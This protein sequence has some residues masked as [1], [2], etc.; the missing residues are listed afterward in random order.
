MKILFVSS[1]VYPLVKTGGLA[2]VAGAL[3]VALSTTCDVK[4]MLPAYEGML[5]MFEQVTNGPILGNPFGFG[6][7]CLRF[8]RLEGLEV[9]FWLVDCPN[10]FHRQG[11]PYLNDDGHDHADNHRRFA[12]LSWA[13]AVVTQYGQLMNWRPD[14]VHAHDWQTGLL[15][16]YLKAWAQRHP[17]LVYTIHN[18]QFTGAYTHEQYI[19]TGLPEHLYNVAGLEY[20]GRYSMLKAGIQYSDAVTTVSPTY[21]KE[22]Q[23]PAFGCGLDALMRDQRHKLSGI[24]NGVDYEVWNPA[25]DEMIDFHYS[26]RDMSG[27]ALNKH[28][29]QKKLGLLEDG[30]RPMFGLIS[31]LSEQKGL[32]L[33]LQVMPEFLEQGV[34]FVLLGSGEKNLESSFRALSGR[35]PEQVAVNFGYNEPLAH[36]IQAASDFLLVPSRFEPCG[37]TQLYALKYGTLPIVRRTGGLA[38]SVWEDIPGRPQTGFTLNEASTRDLW[39]A[40]TRALV[41]YENERLLRQ[42]REQAM[43]QDFSWESAA[44]Q[45]LSLYKRLVT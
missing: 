45:Y 4:V 17:P 23:T 10:L 35:F 37:L 3:P 31:R 12:A 26:T 40:M 19:E 25:T 9:D 21:A 7:L 5:G 33:V 22:I 27:K 2:D 8:G 20:Y 39:Q 43:Q 16:A 15:S 42:M 1:E 29:L 28:A 24:L 14:I 34:Q 41:V 38:D 32:D 13:G 36:Q 18:M 6:E 44:A 30:R 11:G